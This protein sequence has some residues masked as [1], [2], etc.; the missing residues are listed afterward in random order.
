MCFISFIIGVFLCSIGLT[1]FI[2]YLNLLQLG[3]SFL[4]FVKFINTRVEFLVFYFGIL[5]II[6]SKKGWFKNVLFL[7]FTN[8]FSR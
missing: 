2:L 8:K 5:F 1:F 6:F 7:R 3:Y 4:E